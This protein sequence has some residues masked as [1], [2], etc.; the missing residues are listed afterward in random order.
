LGCGLL[1]QDY[2]GFSVEVVNQ[3]IHTLARCDS[4]CLSHDIGV[5]W[6]LAPS[7]IHENGQSDSRRPPKVCK[8][9]EGSANCA[10]GVEH[11]VNYDDV[12][13]VET[14]WELGLSD[15]RTRTDGLQVVA[16]ERYV[17]RTLR[18]CRPLGFLQNGGE[19]PRQLYAAALYADKYKVL[20][21]TVQLDDLVGHALEGSGYGAAVEY[22]FNWH[23]NSNMVGEL[24]LKK[25]KLGAARFEKQAWGK[26]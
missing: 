5:N 19:H 13:V 3:N 21:S 20:S 24:P 22:G 25:C 8:L 23:S 10:S 18:N 17:E 1:H 12:A 9:V 15:D 7:T 26:L 6:E 11:I 4:D 2:F 14:P 16:V